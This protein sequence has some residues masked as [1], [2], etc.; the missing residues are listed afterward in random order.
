MFVV[1]GV[2]GKG[3]VLRWSMCVWSPLQT[4]QCRGKE[5]AAQIRRQID[6]Y[7]PKQ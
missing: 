2:S 5:V 3:L 6:R 4:L 7:G 1:G